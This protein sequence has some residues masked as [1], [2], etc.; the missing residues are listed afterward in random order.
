[1]IRF[2]D[3]KGDVPTIAPRGDKCLGCGS[4]VTG[5]YARQVIYALDLEANNF[6]YKYGRIKAIGVGWKCS[7]CLAPKP[8]ITNTFNISNLVQGEL[9]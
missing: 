3:I 5:S 7:K 9:F 8:I 6:G 4:D 1:M 2:D